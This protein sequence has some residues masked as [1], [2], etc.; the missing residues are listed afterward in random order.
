MAGARYDN[1]DKIFEVIHAPDPLRFDFGQL[2][3]D[4]ALMGYDVIIASGSPRLVMFT[5]G[6]PAEVS[7]VG[8]LSA[9]VAGYS[10]FT[11]Q[12]RKDRLDDILLGHHIRQLMATLS[13]RNVRI[14]QEQ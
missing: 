10:G 14:E 9:K 12:Y 1:I 8:E 13:S 7:S 2:Y 6:M 11:Y 4:L 5:L 3:Q